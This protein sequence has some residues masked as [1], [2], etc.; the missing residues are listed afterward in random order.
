MPMRALHGL[1]GW[2]AAPAGPARRKAASSIGRAWLTIAL[3][4]LAAPLAWAQT[5]PDASA[6]PAATQEETTET[7]QAEEAQAPEAETAGPA[8]TAVSGESAVELAEFVSA[9]L[10]SSG[11]VPGLA[12]VKTT[13]GG[14]RTLS[15]AEAFILLA[16]T[17]YL[18]R[19]S[20]ELP[21]TVP[22]SPANVL[23]PDIDP[24]DVPS[25]EVDQTVG[26]EIPTESFL[27]FVQATVRWVDQLHKVPTAVILQGERLSAAEYMGGLAICI[28]YAYNQ[29]GLL[30]TISLPAYAPPQTWIGAS[31]Q[32]AA[33]NAEEETG[34][35]AAVGEESVLP[36]TP[37]PASA[38]RASP[39][40][41]RPQLSLFPAP[42]STLSG[43]V[44]LVASYT[45]P[46]ATFVTF[47]IDGATRA[48]MNVPP[49]SCRWDT[50]TLPPGNHT[51]R[52]KVYDSEGAELMDQ[53]SAYQ[54]VR[55]KPK[56][57]VE[58]PAENL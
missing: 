34:T 50:S 17:V 8:G 10:A 25:G 29:G 47:D 24:E 1:P 18:W 22:I 3:L 15:A 19:A 14:M 36:V 52:V 27:D 39:V 31:A 4:T 49:Y 23:A 40:Q 12:Q 20:D 6:P 16:R 46:A 48:I 54:V 58:Q 13:D 45:G 42:G 32:V 21:A 56:S 11:Q 44:E 30:D 43:Q 57:A 9:Y 28:E 2:C 33:V 35:E 55:P 5:Y 38:R 51:V 37:P 7:G 41:A 26:R 53:V